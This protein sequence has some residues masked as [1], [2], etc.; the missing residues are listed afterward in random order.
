[1]SITPSG[2][3]QRVFF[4]VWPD[5]AV[6]SAL[7]AWQPA[8]KQL[9]GGRT[10]RADTLH[11]T[12]VFIGE[13]AA[14][15]LEV[16][17]LAAQE[18]CAEGFEICFDEARY[19]GHNHILYAAPGVTPA[20]LQHL[21]V[22]LEASLRRHRFD[23]E[24]R[25]YQPHVTLGRNTHWSDEALPDMLPV[26]WSVSE[27]VLLESVPENAASAYRILARFPLGVAAGFTG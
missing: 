17:T 10:M 12:L 19:W 26:R 8:L 27:F 1:M 23:F 18:V 24:A 16:L 22:E 20:P 7:A 2:S 4:A 25:E 5:A 14:D 21:V 9:C 3:K 13:M 6:R 11:L 15:R